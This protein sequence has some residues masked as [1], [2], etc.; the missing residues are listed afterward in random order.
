MCSA[1]VDVAAERW[2]AAATSAGALDDARGSL[3][4]SRRATILRRLVAVYLGVAALVAAVFAV[5]GGQGI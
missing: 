2:F 3:E 4:R 1:W 5:M